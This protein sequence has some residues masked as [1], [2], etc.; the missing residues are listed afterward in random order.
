MGAE[1][2]GFGLKRRDIL[3]CSVVELLKVQQWNSEIK[4][5]YLNKMLITV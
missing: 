4:F 1:G 5:S 3:K 2:G